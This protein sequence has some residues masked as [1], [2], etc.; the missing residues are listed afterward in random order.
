M[1]HM[2]GI[3]KQGPGVLSHDVAIREHVG[4]LPVELI[5]HVVH[6]DQERRQGGGALGLVGEDRTR[7]NQHG[8]TKS[9]RVLTLPDGENHRAI[10]DDEE[11]HAVEDEQADL[12]PRLPRI[13]RERLEERRPFQH[14]Q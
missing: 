11:R 6:V 5:E 10:A 12:L 2:S 7:G 8:V 3:R 4:M 14:C 1:E 13:H 9:D